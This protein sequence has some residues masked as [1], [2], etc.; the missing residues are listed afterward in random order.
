MIPV[1]IYAVQI[2]TLCGHVY[3][4]VHGCGTGKRRAPMAVLA[5]IQ[6]WTVDFS[7]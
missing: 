2:L 7:G 5:A 4:S 1:Y 6:K 3:V